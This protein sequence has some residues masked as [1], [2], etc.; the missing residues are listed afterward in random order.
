MADA[1]KTESRI[2]TESHL[3]TAYWWSKEKKGFR[4]SLH[5]KIRNVWWRQGKKRN[6]AIAGLRKTGVGTHVAGTITL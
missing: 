6:D 5:P 3:K 1:S 4:V 2:L